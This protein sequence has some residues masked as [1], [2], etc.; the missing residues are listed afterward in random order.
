MSRNANCT[1]FL[2]SIHFPDHWSRFPEA[3]RFVLLMRRLETFCGVQ[4]L[5]YAL[6]FNHFHLLGR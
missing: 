1:L 2:R 4:V 5:T 3:E 6:M